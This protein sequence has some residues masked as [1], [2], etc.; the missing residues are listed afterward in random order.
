MGMNTCE[1]A[2]GSNFDYSSVSDADLITMQKIAR[3]KSAVYLYD[4]RGQFLDALDRTGLYL[5]NRELWRRGAVG[6]VT[7]KQGITR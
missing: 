2:A 5:I 3:S 4:S 1:I 6:G 7:R